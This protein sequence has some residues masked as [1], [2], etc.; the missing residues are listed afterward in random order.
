MKARLPICICLLALV[1][2]Y[3]VFSQQ[4]LQT[5]V[6]RLSLPDKNWSFDISLPGFSV[7]T[8]KIDSAGSAYEFAA[9]QFP[10]KKSSPPHMVN[11]NIQMQPAQLKDTAA[12]FRD[13]SLKK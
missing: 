7:V 13:F 8:E 6:H 11:L 9:G 4:A 1:S 3:P 5:E 12:A 2:S 10:E